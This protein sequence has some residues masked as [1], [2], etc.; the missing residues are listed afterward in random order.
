MEDG[1]LA[2]GEWLAQN[3]IPADAV[4]DVGQTPNALM[5]Q[6]VREADVALFANRGEGGTNL[7]A[8]QGCIPLTRQRA[9]R[10]PTRFYRAVDGWGESD[11]EEMVAAL[12]AVYTDRT[13]ALRIAQRGADA[14]AQ[15]SWAQQ[16]ESLVRTL[17]PLL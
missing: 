9:V 3:G 6:V 12:E 16:V 7:V 2:V 17:T 14:L 4:L 15:L 1:R 8:T 11:I 10:P 5:G 13:A